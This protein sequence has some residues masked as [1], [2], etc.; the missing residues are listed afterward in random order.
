MKPHEAAGAVRP[1][2]SDDVDTLIRLR[3]ASY[4]RPR[5]SD[6]DEL[7]ATLARRLPYIRGLDVGGRLVAAAAW[8]PFPAWIGG[9]RVAT[10]ALAG[11]VSAPEGRRRGH[12]RTLVATGL[13]EQ[14]AEGVGWSGEHPF[15]PRFYDAFG[16]R[17]VPSSCWLDLPFDRLPGR[18]ADVAFGEV[19]RASPEVRA[20]RR[21]FA[22]RHSFTLDRDEPAGF[23]PGDEGLPGR[24]PGVFEAPEDDATIAS[25]Y[26]CDGG[27]A[28]VATEG[29]GHDGVLHVADAAWRDAQAR[30][31]VLAM[32]RAWDGQVGRVRIELPT[33]DPLARRDGPLFARHRTPLQMRIV[34]VTSALA[35]LRVA[36][37]RAA[38]VVLD[39]SDRLAPWN[40]GRWRLTTGP[41]GCAVEACEDEP[42]AATDAGGLVA[43]LSGTP[44]AALLASGEATG[45]SVALSALQAS[46]AD[47]PSFLGL[48][49]F[50]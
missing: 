41:D 3:R 25:A 6:D 14:R 1:I 15:D 31:R 16:Y 46:T 49:D 2:G 8:Y 34:D 26:L 39:L 37:S 22:E 42:D 7:R 23:E 38:T 33:H 10:G 17:T 12:V 24:W 48:V 40:E 5:T 13:A 50:Y 18:A 47:H 27:Y 35:P 20:I 28:I 11:V 19:D 36:A 21:A 44:P 32:L 9:A 45:S 43:L 29:F 30:R 4:G